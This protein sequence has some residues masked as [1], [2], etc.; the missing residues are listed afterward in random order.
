MGSVREMKEFERHLLRQW[1]ARIE[2]QGPSIVRLYRRNDPHIEF[3]VTRGGGKSRISTK[4]RSAE[5]APARSEVR[6]IL[7]LIRFH[8]SAARPGAIV[9]AKRA[10]IETE[11][12]CTRERCFQYLADAFPV[13]WRAFQSGQRLPRSVPPTRGGAR[14]AIVQT[15]SELKNLLERAPN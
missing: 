13:E 9:R 1:D 2:W 5:D 8:I 12:V 15:T 3:Y 11:G 4:V 14:D 7:Q 6:R 10:D